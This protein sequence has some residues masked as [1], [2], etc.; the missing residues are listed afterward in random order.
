MRRAGHIDHCAQSV[1]A[2]KQTAAEIRESQRKADEA[3]K[4]IEANTPDM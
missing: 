2:Y 4:V 1:P 3:M